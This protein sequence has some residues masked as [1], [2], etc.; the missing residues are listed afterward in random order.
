MTTDNVSPYIT[1]ALERARIY[2]TQAAWERAKR[3]SDYIRDLK[4]EHEKAEALKRRRQSEN[5]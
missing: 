3:H 1:R 5:D 4:H 2:P